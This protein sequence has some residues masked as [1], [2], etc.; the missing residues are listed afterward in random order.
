[1]SWYMGVVSCVRYRGRRM[2]VH[3]AMVLMT[4]FIMRVVVMMMVVMV[5]GYVKVLPLGLD[6]CIR[7]SHCDT[8]ASGNATTL[9]SPFYKIPNDHP[10]YIGM[11]REF[12]G[13]SS[14]SCHN[15]SQHHHGPSMSL[16][17]YVY[18]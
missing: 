3:V 6:P 11:M 16:W 17:E 1:M 12:F 9:W 18:K 7:H 2:G 13:A 14:N 4:I 15:H 8:S 5:M 10:H